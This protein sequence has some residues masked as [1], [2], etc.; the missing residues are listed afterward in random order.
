MCERTREEAK[1][2]ASQPLRTDRRGGPPAKSCWIVKLPPQPSRRQGAHPA[3]RTSRFPLC[4][5]QLLRAS[6]GGRHQLQMNHLLTPE[7]GWVSRGPPDARAL[8]GDPGPPAELEA[9]TSLHSDCLP[10]PGPSWPARKTQGLPP[11]TPGG[12]QQEEGKAEAA[13]SRAP[14]L[15]HPARREGPHPRLAKGQGPGHAAWAVRAHPPE[16]VLNKP[17]GQQQA[18][19]TRDGEREGW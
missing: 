6:A 15:T 3:P 19:R 8:A 16:H 11:P 13:G 14:L 10:E 12:G 18:T 7:P 1:A 4:Q 17:P 2:A 9:L 5:P